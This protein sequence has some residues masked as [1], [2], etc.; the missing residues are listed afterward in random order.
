MAHSGSCRVVR[1][2]HCLARGGGTHDQERTSRLPQGEPPTESRD[3]GSQAVLENLGAAMARLRAAL[4]R[5]G[6]EVEANAQAEWVHAKPGLRQ[7][8][9]DLQT[10]V[11]ELAQRAKAAL[12]ELGARLDDR[13]NR[14]D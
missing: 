6:E 9:S 1:R 8:I 11:D 3:P 12:G 13:G 10:M 2:R 14:D 5:V 7:G 4:D